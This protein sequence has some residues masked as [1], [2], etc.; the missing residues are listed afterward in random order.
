MVSHV[1]TAK[2]IG[3]LIS[4]GL[5]S[6]ILLAYLLEKGYRVQPLYMA[7]GCAWQ[8]AEQRA[9]HQFVKALDDDA[10]ENVVEL[11]MPV[12]D[13][14]GDH[15]S[16]TGRDVP[17]STTPDEAVFL[18]GRNPLLLVKA[19]L[20]CS[21]HAIP[22]LAMATLE[23]N[24]FADATPCCFQQFEQ[25]LAT[26]TERKVEIL[27]PFAGKSK[28]QV[29]ALGAELPLHLTFSCLAPQ[30]DRHCGD[31]NKCA[32]RAVVL[33]SMPA[34]DPTIYASEKNFADPVL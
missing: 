27:R 18:W 5:D 26:A 16:I 4:G 11:Q 32:E 21:M 29:V 15:W 9:V 12:G 31:C 30:G 33:Q 6:T 3:L 2:T 28:Q 17:D 1:R 14:Y 24:P 23:C 25:A 8:Q 20:W 7:T 10:V 34:G 13:L 19:M 22:R